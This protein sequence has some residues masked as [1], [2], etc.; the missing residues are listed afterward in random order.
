MTGG[1]ISDEERQSR[2]ESWES[3]SWN[4]FLSSGIP[5]SADANAHAM[6]WVN[7]EVTRAERAAELRA[8]RGLP[9]DSEAE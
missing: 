8:A 4:Q 2:L 5:L 6:R 7:G 3:A 9:P 1:G